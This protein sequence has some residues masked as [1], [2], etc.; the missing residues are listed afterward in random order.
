MRWENKQQQVQTELAKHSR[1][2]LAW[3]GDEGQNAD[4]AARL[5]EWELSRAIIRRHQDEFWA[6]RKQVKEHM[7]GSTRAMIQQVSH[8]KTESGLHPDDDRRLRY[9]RTIGELAKQASLTEADLDR[10]RRF[11]S[12]FDPL[13]TPF[14]HQEVLELTSRC[15]GR[16]PAAELRHRLAAI[17]FSTAADRS[18]RNVADALQFAN[19]TPSAFANK[20]EQFDHLNALLQMLLAR[21]SARG[22]FRPTSSRIALNDIEQHRR[23]RKLVYNARLTG[24][25]GDHAH[26]RVGRPQATSRTPPHPPAAH[27]SQPSPAVPR[28]KPAD[29]RG[30]R[31]HASRQCN[32][33]ANPSSIVIRQFL[34]DAGGSL[35]ET[36]QTFPK[37]PVVAADNERCVSD[38]MDLVRGSNHAVERNLGERD[39]GV[40]VP[41]DAGRD[42]L[43][44]H[45]WRANAPVP[46]LPE[47]RRPVLPGRSGI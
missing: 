18:I 41:L 15:S 26:C 2:L 38:Q 14:L 43:S 40:A 35:C 24:G 21:W 20:A 3:C 1:F 47:G 19:S 45:R 10:L 36:W 17:Y 5:S 8:T 7:T 13:I 25:R 12:P 6:Y 39:D 46:V 42:R 16:D 9:F 33:V 37:I 29:E 32:R 31:E 28:E 23:R 27:L 44:N 34:L 30:H 4:V 11:E 22:E